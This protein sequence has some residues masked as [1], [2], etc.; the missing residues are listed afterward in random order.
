M[1]LIAPY[2]KPMVRR[3]RRMLLAAAACASFCG[4][5]ACR[6]PEAPAPLPEHCFAP[7]D[8]SASAAVGEPEE[9]PEA[10]EP[11]PAGPVPTDPTAA[12]AHARCASGSAQG[13]AEL[14]H[15]Y[16]E[17]SHGEA[18]GKLAARRAADL[19]WAALA[20]SPA[21]TATLE[22]PAA[23]VAAF[24]RAFLD[25]VLPALDGKPIAPTAHAFGECMASD[26]QFAVRRT[27][28][29]VA[30]RELGLVRLLFPS[31]LLAGR[32][33]SLGGGGWVWSVTFLGASR[34][35]MPSGVFAGFIDPADGS[36]LVAYHS[37]EG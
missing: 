10:R 1:A 36:L 4:T 9:D 16:L 30:Y 35:F 6:Q 11:T 27:A 37:P 29:R 26:A 25:Q 33:E 19:E 18:L 3:A 7:T 23:V 5:L 13:C 14:A 21:R 28:R 8:P 32:P 24:R 31:A 17:G 2:A 20:G 34:R 22:A 15:W 12:A